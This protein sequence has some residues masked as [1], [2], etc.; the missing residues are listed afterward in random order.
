MGNNNHRK[1]SITQGTRA[2]SNFI[3]QFH[4]RWQ[5]NEKS[6]PGVVS[7]LQPTHTRSLYPVAEAIFRPLYSGES[8][9]RN[10]QITTTPQILK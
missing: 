10:D 7:G 3:I 8:Y 6:I 1:Y 4:R 9:S 5:S 2:F